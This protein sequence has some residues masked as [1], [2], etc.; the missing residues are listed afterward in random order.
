MQVRQ[1]TWN[2]TFGWHGARDLAAQLVVYFG[3]R[4]TLAD[5]TRFTELKAMFPDSHLIGCSTGGQISGDDVR[6]NEIA[7]VAMHFDA[8][9]L[10]LACE[11]VAGPIASRS[12]GEAIG[13][14]LMDAN[15]AG[16]FILSDGLNV[17]GSELVAGIA[18]VVGAKVP[19]TGGLAG[20]GSF[21]V[22]TLVG[23][24]CAPRSHAVAA[25]GFYG[26]VVRIGHGSAGGWDV[27]GPHRRITKST[28]NVLFELDGEPALDLYERYLGEDESK[29]LP[30][31]ALL[32]PLQIHNPQ[33]RDEVVR[34]VLAIDR[35]A[36]SMT[37]AGDVPQGWI[38]QL[39]R[40][41]FDHLAQGAAVAARNAQK[42]IGE[43]GGNDGVA[44]MVS[45]IG[46]RLLMGQS[47][48]DEIEVA[49]K[50]LGPK[51]ARIG[52]YSYG[53]ISPHVSSGA[54]GLH[55]QT[56]TVTTITEAAG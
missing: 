40:G 12:A 42:M 16:I 3:A 5:A 34:T 13:R 4:E 27:F 28:G 21:F 19:L 56:M 22:E 55:N 33:N 24:D 45:C 10:R 48:T 37:F 2:S 43:H 11:P 31:S 15:L 53:E 46:R 17:N 18:Q 1:L 32:F 54:C 14:K 38:A 6:D 35:D 26:D 29:G 36:R 25:I 44:L 49:G 7:A 20:D 47:I 41:N 52:F 9:Q 39:M 51:L 8:T 50:E 30:G 23:A